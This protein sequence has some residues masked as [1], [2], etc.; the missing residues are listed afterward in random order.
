[1]REFI[2]QTVDSERVRAFPMPVDVLV[3]SI[4]RSHAK[5]KVLKLECAALCWTGY[6]VGVGVFNL[7]YMA[8]GA[9]AL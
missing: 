6:R 8:C 1:M 7:E 5:F 2:F 4:L 9:G 3:E